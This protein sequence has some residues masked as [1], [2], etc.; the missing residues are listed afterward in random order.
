MARTAPLAH[1]FGSRVGRQF[2]WSVRVLWSTLSA[3]GLTLVV[4]L[5]SGG[6]ASAFRAVAGNGVIRAPAPVSIVQTSTATDL[7]PGASR[8]LSGEFDNRTSARIFVK[9]VEAWVVPFRE[10]RNGALPACT[11]AD[12]E[13][14]GNSNLSVHIL[15]GADVG[16]WSGL[17]LSMRESAPSNCAGIGLSIAYRVG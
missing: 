17:V 16:S 15:R 8:A 5:A 11:Q 12:F 10:Q 7:Y 4:M 3:F 13:I 2:S 9:K 14:S 1:R 6:A